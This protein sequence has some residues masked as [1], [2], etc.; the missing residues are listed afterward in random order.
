MGSFRKA[1][2]LFW[3]FNGGEALMR[4][5]IG[6]LTRFAKSLG[7]FVSITTNGVLIPQK[8]QEIRRADLINISLEGP[9]EIHDA[10]RSNSYDRMCKGIEALAENGIRFSFS[11]QINKQN[12]DAL[13]FVLDFAEKYKTKVAFQPVRIQKEDTGAKARDYFPT[14]ERMQEALDFL[15]LEKS[16]GRSVANSVSFFQQI[17]DS[18][19]SGRPEMD[20]WAGRIYCAITSEG[21]VTACCDT[22]AE[23]RA[24]GHHPSAGDAVD[25]FYRMPAF[26]CATCYAAIPLEAN[27]AMST[28]LKNPL[29]AFSQI[30]SFLPTP[31]RKPRS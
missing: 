12:I 21:A 25:S 9:K 31:F 6:D 11:V 27:I 10:M 8:V 13:G 7:M 28:C 2:C 22:L 17:R 16:R 23:A 3:A 18:W 1:G 26:N 15:L 4:D 30:K 20:C 24:C 19:P 29:A 5:D 14:R